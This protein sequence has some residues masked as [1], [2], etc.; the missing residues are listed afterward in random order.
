MVLLE[1][2]LVYRSKYPSEGEMVRKFIDLL[3][4]DAGCFSRNG[5]S[6]HLTGSAWVVDES[7]TKTLLV[8]H[9]K[10]GKWIQPGGHADSERDLFRVALRELREET[11]LS[12]VRGHRDEIFDIDIH[13]IPESEAE[14]AHYHYDVRFLLIA[15]DTSAKIKPS[16]ESHDVRWIEL[17]RLEEFTCEDSI[18][19]MRRK[20]IAQRSKKH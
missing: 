9:R 3:E 5:A 4:A 17:D 1:K 20:C 10:L 19:R 8:H 2:L 18:L 12:G 15:K 13:L 14:V 7:C 16:D 6:G 11:G